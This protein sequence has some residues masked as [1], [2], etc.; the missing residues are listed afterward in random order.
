MEQMSDVMGD[1]REL[2]QPGLDVP[3]AVTRGGRQGEGVYREGV[4]GG[5][6]V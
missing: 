3:G 2:T 1:E 5:D 6:L 4:G